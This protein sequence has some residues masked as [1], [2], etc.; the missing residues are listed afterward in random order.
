MAMPA[1]G[2]IAIISAPQTCG[3]ICASVA[4]TVGSLAALGADACKSTPV[5]MRNFYNYVGPAST[6]GV[7]FCQISCAGA[8][9]T[10]SICNTICV[11]T[12]SALVA[13]QCYIITLNH[14]LTSNTQ[15]GSRS[16]LILCCNGTALYN[17]DV[18]LGSTAN[19]SC[20]F[21]LC[22]TQTLCFMQC[23]I[24]PVAGGTGLSCVCTCITTISNSTPAHGLF[25]N[26]GAACIIFTC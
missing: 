15:T 12:P 8:C 7:G 3:S 23:A 5:C 24:H 14:C 21:T 9:N 19:F 18:S 6:R 1:S 25:A 20:T 2:N 10:A 22:D 4:Q 16:C 17:C 26:T 13:G 11:C